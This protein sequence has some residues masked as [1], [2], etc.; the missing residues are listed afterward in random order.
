MRERKKIKRLR[1]F[2]S[3][4]KFNVAHFIV[5]QRDDFEMDTVESEGG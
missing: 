4:I 5:G 3:D 1:E 2:K